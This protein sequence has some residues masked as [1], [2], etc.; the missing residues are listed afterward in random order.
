MARRKDWSPKKR[1]TAV[2]LRK[3]GYSYRQIA[4]KIGDGVTASGIRKL[5]KRFEV[6]GSVTTQPGKG[7]K[8]STT[9]KTDRRI[10]RMALKN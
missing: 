5:F 2:T 3:E 10:S 1:A 7:R 6:S 8:R 4:V 9:P